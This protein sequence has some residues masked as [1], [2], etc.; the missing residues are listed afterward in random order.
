MIGGYQVETTFS[1]I[2]RVNHFSI[3]QVTVNNNIMGCQTKLNSVNSCSFNPVNIIETGRQEPLLWFKFFH[4]S[5]SVQSSKTSFSSSV[6]V[7]A[8]Y[9][10]FFSDVK[11]VLSLLKECNIFCM[12]AAIAF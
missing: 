4:R 10:G 12:T 2:F 9:C 8:S 11:C 3:L 6:A 7:D 1:D 5:L